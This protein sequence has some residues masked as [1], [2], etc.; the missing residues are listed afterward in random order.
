MAKTLTAS[1]TMQLMQDVAE[2]KQS[3]AV[4]NMITEKEAAELLN[5]GRLTLKVYVSKGK[6]PADCFTISPINGERFY[7]RTKIIGLK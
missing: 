3:L 5:I 2:I 1:K 7:D 6:V 4:K